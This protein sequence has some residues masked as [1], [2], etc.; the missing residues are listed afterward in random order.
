MDAPGGYVLA[1]AWLV[2]LGLAIGL[3][4][5][6]RAVFPALGIGP[7]VTVMVIIGEV[8]IGDTITRADLVALSTLCML[9]AVC[10]VAPV[11]YVRWV[12]RQFRDAERGLISR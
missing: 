4:A 12:R 9:G 5:L 8:R 10:A 11:A 3:C 2:A 7:A 1:L 6:R